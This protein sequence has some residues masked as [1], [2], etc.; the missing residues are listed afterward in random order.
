MVPDSLWMKQWEQSR[1]KLAPLSDLNA[2][3]E[4]SEVEGRQLEV[5][6]IGP[7]SIPSGEILVRD[8]FV[9]LGNKSEEPYFLKAPAGTYQTQ[10]CVIKPEDGDCARYAA[11]RLCFSEKKAV[12]FEE[13]LIGN[14]ELEDLEEGQYFGFGVDAGLAAICDKVVR[15]AYCDFLKTLKKDGKDIYIDCLD[16]LFKENYK[17]NPKFQRKGG[18]WLCWNV[19]GTEYYMPIFTSGFGD[20][21]YPVYWGYN[22]DGEICQLI[23]HL[24]DIHYAYN[25][26]EEED[27]DEEEI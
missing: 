14:E 24:I 11:V 19:P 3:F 18:D 13:A 4:Q 5:M 17:K 25:G 9:F 16:D 26:D 22:E 27:E 7:C 6:D 1:K 8:P 2:Y 10:V 12:R 15:D 21:A 20:G 23:V